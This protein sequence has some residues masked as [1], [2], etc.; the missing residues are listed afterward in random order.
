MNPAKQESLDILIALLRNEAP[1]DAPR[2]GHETYLRRWILEHGLAGFLY[3]AREQFSRHFAEH[4]AAAYKANVQRNLLFMN[5]YRQ[6]RAAC[7]ERGLPAP[8]ALKGLA[9]LDR[10]HP[11]GE[12]PLT[13]IDIYIDPQHLEPTHSLL[14]ELGFAARSEK[15]WRAN[16]HKSTF[17]KNVLGLAVTVETHSQLFYNQPADFKPPTVQEGDLTILAPDIEIVYLSAHLVHQH[18]FLKL[19][20]LLDLQRLTR[21]NPAAWSSEV[22][23]Q[24]ERLKVRTSARAVALSLKNLFGHDIQTPR[25]FLPLRWCLNWPTLVLLNESR[26]KYLFMKHA[27]KDSWRE[28][29]AYDWRWLYFRMENHWFANKIERDK[30]L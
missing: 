29:L 10:V 16:R 28:S 20:W 21:A 26:W 14:E 9:L 13:D 2:A 11:L 18:T 30:T 19:F 17:G 24:A 7:L 23:T 4:L 27:A 3:G 1:K 8:V 12:R 22:W 5:E 15:K 6:I 25:G